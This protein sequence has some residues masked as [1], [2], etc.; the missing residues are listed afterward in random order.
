[1]EKTRITIEVEPKLKEEF[2]KKAKKDGRTMK[3]L[4]ENW[5]KSYIDTPTKQ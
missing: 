5:I 3:W 1:M 4:F 2:L